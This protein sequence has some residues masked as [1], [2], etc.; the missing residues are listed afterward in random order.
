MAALLPEWSPR[1]AL[2]L[3][4]P[5]RPDIWPDAGLAAQRSLIKL[6]QDIEPLMRTL[7]MQVVV[8]VT[9]ACY[10]QAAAQL[11]VYVRLQQATYADIWLRDSGP[12][13]T[14]DGQAW[15]AGF[16]GWQGLDPAYHD[17]LIGRQQLLESFALQA[18][19]LP[20]VLEGGS[21]HTDGAGTAVYVA[22]SVLT[23]GRNPALSHSQFAA[24]LATYL[25]IE[26]L[27]ALPEGLSCDETGGHVDNLLCFLDAQHIAVTLPDSPTH[28]EY[29][30]CYR[31]FTE[32][33]GLCNLQGHPFTLIPL[34]LPQLYLSRA[35]AQAIQ[36]VEGVFARRPGMPLSASY[37]N[38]IC[39]PGYYLLPVFGCEEDSIALDRLQQALPDFT[40]VSVDARDL[41]VG[42]GGWHCAS[43]TLPTVVER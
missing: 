21:L 8:Q 16:N 9:A 13:Y 34:P 29:E 26:Q 10:Q 35:E 37:C 17:D 6:L 25:G 41:L 4:W 40:I 11:P 2:C 7:E 23:A 3:R 38:G 20:L 39:L 43:H 14:A 19:E 12:F 15:L 1:R 5:W 42:G 22:S 33:Q 27:L 30:R 24:M 36:P 31:V 18:S 32:L 28:P